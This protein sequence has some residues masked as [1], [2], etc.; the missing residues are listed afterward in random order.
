MADAQAVLGEQGGGV[1]VV[2]GDARQGV[3]CDGVDLLVE[4]ARMWAELG[5]W[6]TNGG[7]P[8]FHIHGVTGPDEYTTVVNDN[9]FTNVMARDNLRNAVKTVRWLAEHRPDDHAAAAARLHLDDE[10]V[11]EW[12][13]AASRL[14]LPYEEHLGIHPQD[15]FFLDR[16]VWDLS[17]TPRELRP[18][19]L[20]YHPLVIYRFQVL[21]QADV[22]ML[23]IL[24]WERFTPA[25]HAASR[26]W[27]SY[28]PS[29]ALTGP[30][31][32]LESE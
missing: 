2:G 32:L 20:H 17:Q 4:T 19:L 30:T 23:L 3:R 22:V 28:R 25:A 8:T 18:L 1:G 11:I 6:R 26:S 10:E 5:F 29:V 31:S 9:L 15:D 13:R 27:A 21:K 24:L 14:M 12:E 7:D 16:E